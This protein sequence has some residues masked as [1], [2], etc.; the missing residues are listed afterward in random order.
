MSAT[1]TCALQLAVNAAAV[2]PTFVDIFGHDE[3]V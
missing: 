1:E 3:L 2:Y